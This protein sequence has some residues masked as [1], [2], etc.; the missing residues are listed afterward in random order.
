M[1]QNIYE[2]LQWL[3]EQGKD[4]TEWGFVENV[5]TKPQFGSWINHHIK[6]R[7]LYYQW[8]Q[9]DRESNSILVNSSPDYFLATD[10]P[11]FYYYIWL[12][13]EK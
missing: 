6:G 9:F 10:D 13:D 12:L 1:K 8:Y 11:D 4:N 2:V 7:A 3:N 5:D